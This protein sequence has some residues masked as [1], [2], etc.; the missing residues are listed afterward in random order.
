M[1]LEDRDDHQ[2]VDGAAIQETVLGMQEA[3]LSE[4]L[5]RKA[6]VNNECISKEV[7]LLNNLTL[8]ELAEL[9]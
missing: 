8:K 9:S 7:M 6:V 5:C 4:V 3:E 2:S 1:E